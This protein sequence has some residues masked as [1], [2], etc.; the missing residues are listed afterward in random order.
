YSDSTH[1]FI[2]Y[3]EVRFN[4][5]LSENIL[6]ALSED[7]DNMVFIYSTNEAYVMEAINKLR[8]Y[9]KDYSIKVFGCPVWQTWSNIDIEYLHDLQ[10][11][12]YAPF[13]IDYGASRTKSFVSKC[14]RIYN[15]EPHVVMAK[16]YNYCFLGYDIAMYFLTAL[17]D[18]GNHF[19]QCIE[20]LKVDLLLSDYIF[21]R[22]GTN[23]GLEN[24]SISILNYNNNFTVNKINY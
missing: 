21:V 1:K 14:R 16:G 7:K 5:T 11:D 23:S 10:L 12:I 2:I 13:Y 9:Q 4:D 8:T 22:K 15:Y 17:K 24:I 20:H 18:Y 3:Q 19:P 6:Y